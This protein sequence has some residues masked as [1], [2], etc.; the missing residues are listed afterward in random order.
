MVRIDSIGTNGPEVVEEI[1]TN[2]ENNGSNQSST[3]NSETDNPTVDEFFQ[4]PNFYT[5]AKEYWA[6]IAPTINGMLGG[7]SVIDRTDIQGSSDFLKELLKMK[8]AVDNKRALDCGAGIGRITK[9]L[10]VKSFE[11]VDLVEQDANFVRKAHEYLKMNG[12]KHPNVGE[13]YNEGLQNFTPQPGH[14]DVIWM[15]W[16]L[17]HLTDTDLKAFFERCI[18]ALKP[19][20]CI[21]I[22]EN[23][24]A[25]DDFTID[26]ED[27]S[28]TR[29]LRVTK[30]IL[31]AAGL[32][33]IK[34]T[35]QKNFIK[36]LFPVYSLACKPVRTNTQNA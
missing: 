20:G 9:N 33:I 25:T 31:T 8:P 24:T 13:I 32:R 14:Y 2:P 3:T 11:A 15:Q 6:N 19:N 21:V 26:A 18:L 27:S 17:G 4:S 30:D 10:L 1:V 34:T 16:V 23:F 5:N 22:K 35:E 36:G 7:L 28:V 12:S 29:S